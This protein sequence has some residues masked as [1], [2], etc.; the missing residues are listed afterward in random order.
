MALEQ[1][2]FFGVD[3]EIIDVIVKAHQAHRLHA[4]LH[5]AHQP[6][7]FIPG[8]VKAAVLFNKLD[9]RLEF[10]GLLGITHAVSPFMTNVTRAGGISSSGSTKQHILFEG[11]ARHAGK[12][13]G[14]FI[15]D[16][17]GFARFFDG[18]YPHGAVTAGTSQYDRDS[19]LPVTCGYR[20][21]Q[22]VCLRAQEVYE[23]R[24]CQ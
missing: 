3:L 13:G 24:L 15:L 21:E 11:R 6:G 20:F 23:L 2:E 14:R 8:E 19:P 18:A 10:L 9:E 16:D 17:D 4:L 5:S 7:G 22:K 12:L 1:G